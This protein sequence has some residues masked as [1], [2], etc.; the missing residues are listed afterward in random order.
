MNNT[1]KAVNGGRDI[2]DIPFTQHTFYYHE[3]P[4]PLHAVIRSCGRVR[5]T[6]SEYYWHG[7]KRGDRAFTVIQYT[8]VGE[9]AYEDETGTQPLGPG[10]LMIAAVPGD[11]AYY[12]PD[13]SEYWDFCYLVAAGSE[14]NRIAREVIGQAGPVLRLN[15][16]SPLLRGLAA[17]FGLKAEAMQSSV[18][19]NSRSAYSLLMLLCDEA[20]LRTVSENEYA[21]IKK[22]KEYICRNY[23]KGDISVDELADKAGYSRSHYTRLFGE[24]YGYSPGRFQDHLRMKKALRLLSTSALSIKET[25]AA[26]GYTDSNYFCRLFKKNTGTSPGQFRRS[27]V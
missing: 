24:I 1:D 3:R 11:H 25:A 26:C 22:T 13:S 14:F 2:P 8:L 27:G 12:L 6:E 15:S 18:F 17:F 19:A 20:R 21:G 10:T 16:A 5:E 23:D 7:R 4:L 9:G